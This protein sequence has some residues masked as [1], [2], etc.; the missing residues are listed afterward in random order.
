MNDKNFEKLDLA[1]KYYLYGAKY[2]L[3]LKAYHLAKSLHVKKRKDGITPE[4]QHQV[5]IALF[6]ITLRLKSEYEERALIYAL[7]HD[8][9][10][11]F[12]KV[13]EF[14]MV[15]EFGGEITGDLK[16]IS[17]KISGVKTYNHYTEYFDRIS[18]RAL[19]A[20]VKGC[21]RIHNLQSMHGVFNLEKQKEYVKEAEIYFLPMLKTA[22]HIDEE[23]FF[24]FQNVRTMLKNQIALIKA[25]IDTETSQ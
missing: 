7:L 11:D 16:L 23:I 14:Q 5:E 13:S 19:L 12:E 3:A 20:L 15:T 4:F 6:I 10:E 18:T 21:D 17:K 22:S 24:S 2:N 8:V 25:I 1:L 9:L